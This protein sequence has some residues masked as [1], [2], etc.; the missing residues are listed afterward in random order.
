[1][2]VAEIDGVQVC[3]REAPG[4]LSAGLV[5]GCGTRD[6]TFLTIGV[7]HLVEHLVMAALPR[8]HH[9]HNA[10]VDLVCTEFFATGRPE[11]IVSFLRAVCDAIATVPVDRLV[12][13]AG[14]LDAEAGFAVHPTGAVL[15]T[16][17]YGA[18]DVGL[19]TYAGPGHDRIGADAVLAHAARFF[20]AGN[21]ALWLTGPPPPGL[22]LPLPPGARVRRSEPVPLTRDGP[23]W[24]QELVPAC[25]LLLSG[26]R[27][28]AWNIAMAVLDERIRAEARHRRGLS[29][30]V[31]GEVV[32]VGP[33][34]RQYLIGADARDG[35]DAAVAEIIWERTRQ[36]AANGPTDAELDHEKTGVVE[37]HQDPRWPAEEAAQCARAAVLGLPRDDPQ[38]RLAA[39]AALTGDD[40]ARCLTAAL[41]TAL[42]AVPPDAAPVLE[43]MSD[44]GCPRTTTVPPGRPYT[45]RPLVRLLT[46]QLRAP[47]H[48]LTDTGLARR[49]P[50][51]DVHHTSF[52]DIVAVEVDG[53]DRL[54]F[55][56]NGCVLPIIQDAFR[57]GETLIRAIDTAVPAHVRYVCH[58]PGSTP[59]SAEVIAHAGR[60][61]RRRNRYLNATGAVLFALATVVLYL[62]WTWGHASLWWVV[63]GAAVTLWCAWDARP[64]RRHLPPPVAPAHAETAGTVADD[65]P[66]L[67]RFHTAE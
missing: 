9:D 28:P 65:A 16:R 45:M 36:L 49:D 13:E 8:V 58:L 52:A 56:G 20:V 51:G 37:T 30:D 40:V 5:F 22:R 3:W 32:P 27:D 34:A 25:G 46:R 18:R 35:Q 21:A 62:N 66:E 10:S 43:G 7:T 44:G 11:Q 41:P 29:Y 23:S 6:E 53:D 1:V 59:A 50:D 15:L 67:R 64:A 54:V 4:P 63:L 39:V 31:F 55:A 26:D 48:Y 60:A 38:T 47:R 12:Q 61:R 24:S 14:V 33:E 17:R 2:N 42:I 57:G 19:E